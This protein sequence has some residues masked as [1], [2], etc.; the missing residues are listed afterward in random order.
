LFIEQKFRMANRDLVY[1]SNAPLVEVEKV[2]G[3][4]NSVLSPAS[5]A[6]SVAYDAAVVR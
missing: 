5:Q 6:S 4:F 2:I 1:V 3:I